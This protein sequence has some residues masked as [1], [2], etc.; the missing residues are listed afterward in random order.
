MSLETRL[1]KSR[2][3]QK[4]KASETVPLW[5]EFQKRGIIFEVSLKSKPLWIF[6]NEIRVDSCSRVEGNVN[7]GYGEGVDWRHGD[8]IPE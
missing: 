4:K 2:K 7:S 6:R 1:K 8:W 3:K 5:F